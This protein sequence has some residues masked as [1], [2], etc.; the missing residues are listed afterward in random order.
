MIIAEKMGEEVNKINF[1]NIDDVFLL[2]NKLLMMFVFVFNLVKK[3]VC[4]L[5]GLNWRPPV[6][7]RFVTRLVLYRWAK[8]ALIISRIA[9]YRTIQ[10]GIDHTECHSFFFLSFFVRLFV[11]LFVCIWVRIYSFRIITSAIRA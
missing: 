11:R 6:C 2:F 1:K 4:L 10:N 5:S 8:K 3:I 7:Y 9:L